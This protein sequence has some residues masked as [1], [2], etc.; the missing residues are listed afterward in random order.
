MTP[1][2]SEAIVCSACSG[3]PRRSASCSACGGAGIGVPS[4]YGF[5]VWDVSVEP[6]AF[7]FRTFRRRANAVVNLGFGIAAAALVGLA[8]LAWVP[9]LAGDP[10]EGPWTA[11]LQDARLWGGVLLAC[12][13]AAR[14]RHLPLHARPLPNWRKTP[15]VLAKELAAH[16]KRKAFRLDVS[17]YFTDAA[18]EIV[19]NA[20]TL[21]AA[22]RQTEVTPDALFAAA[23][24]SPAGGWLSAR[25]GLKFDDMKGPVS[26]VL[27]AGSQGLPPLHLATASKAA[28]AQAFAAAEAGRR[29]HVGAFDVLAEAFAA[30]PAMQDVLDRLGAAPDD[31]RRAIRWI[32]LREQL[33]DDHARFAWLA[34]LK[35]AGAMDRAMTARKTPLLDQF[36]EDLTLAVRS[37]Y[38]PPIVGREAEGEAMMRALEAGRGVVLVGEVGCGKSALVEQLA[39]RMVEEDVPEALQD[40]RLVSVHL[41]QLIASGDASLAP[42]RLLELLQE[43]AEAGNVVLAL[44][45]IEALAG[46]GMRSGTLDLAEILA[47]GV[48]K[49]SVRLIATSTPRAWTETLEAR[50]LGRM[51]APV[52]VAPMGP[53]ETLEVL[54][55]R[56]YLVEH[57][58]QASFTLAALS[59]I[60]R[61]APRFLTEK[62]SPASAMDLAREAATA[63]HTARGNGAWIGVEDVARVVQQRTGVPTEAITRDEA[64]RLL[65]L[66]DR[67]RD[68]VIGQDAAVRAVADALRRS[69]AG[70]RSQARPIG[71]FL[72]LGPTGV[73]KTELAKAVAAEYFGDASAMV[74]LDMSEYQQASSLDR[75]IGAPGDT[76][77]G[78]LT[79]AVRKRPYGLVLL[80][81]LEKAHPDI[82]TIFLQ[83]MDDGRIT[84]GV[85]R[86]VDFTQTLLV[87]TSNAGAP[88]I[89][90]RIQAGDD[91]AKIKTGLLERE[92]RGTFRPEF[93]NRFDGVIVFSPLSESDVVQVARLLVAELGRRLGEKGIE[94]EVEDAM[95]ADLAR[96]GYDPAYGARP[97]RRLIQDTLENALAKAMIQ[98]KAHRR[99]RFVLKAD[100]RLELHSP[101]G[102]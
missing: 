21:A 93:L 44:S 80:D 14:I 28:L 57:Q 73:G 11:A 3:D 36:S 43:V 94:L 50:A 18:W 20:A 41:P 74:R 95:V 69:R 70:I 83:A 77:G 30:A 59:S 6:A 8:A 61:L 98:G 78:L 99:D 51:L 67:L 9:V 12:F 42:E 39:R 90:E 65:D 31:V 72:F 48:G 81:E 76:R 19:R 92:L 66:E 100:G 17:P 64:D 32:G 91:V 46:A 5:L 96:R 97:L 16:P 13:M 2:P 26:A 49:S 84:D 33:L 102:P 56:A 22:H 87:A 34:S 62:A 38:V 15:E 63:A 75:L 35:P 23:L 71:S 24:A 85:G 45:G 55:A 40:K 53:D 52:R 1:L 4:P 29:Q 82:L 27:S 37:G 10:W 60:A 101:V 79:E 25:L 89:Q 58:A 54:L 68:R 7:A 88:F 47:N 86:T